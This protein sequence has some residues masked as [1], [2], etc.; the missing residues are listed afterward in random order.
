GLGRIVYV[1]SSEQLSAWLAELGAPPSPVR[2]LPIREVAPGVAV[3]GPVP[4]LTDQV[5][6][7]QRRF[8]GAS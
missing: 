1:S 7:L 4:E 3:E 8:Y 5:Y 2:P 6:N